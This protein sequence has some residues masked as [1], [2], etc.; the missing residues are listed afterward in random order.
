MEISFNIKNVII[1]QLDSILAF[2]KKLKFNMQFF[3]DAI[4]ESPA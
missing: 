4:K 1:F 2:I 3:C